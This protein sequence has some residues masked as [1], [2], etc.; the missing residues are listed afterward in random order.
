[1]GGLGNILVVDDEPD[2][3]KKLE[4][5]LFED[6]FSVQTAEGVEDALEVLQKHPTHVAVI[7]LRL[8]GANSSED[9]G[10]ALLE[11]VHRLGLSGM[12]CS[13]V[14][15]GYATLA[16][17]S[18]AFTE[19][20]VVDFFEKN[21]FDSQ[22]Q[23]FRQ[24]VKKA[25]LKA[26]YAQLSKLGFKCFKTGA[27]CSHIIVEDP[28]R[29]FVAMPYR[30]EQNNVYEY[31]LK[32]LESSLDCEIGRADEKVLSIDL[33]CKICQFIQ[34]ASICVA[35]ITTWNANVMFELGLMYGWGKP[36]ILI[37]QREE[38]NEKADLKGMEFIPYDM[39]DYPRLQES[40]T[41][42][43]QAMGIRVEETKP[44]M[45][46]GRL[47]EAEL[48]AET[49]AEIREL[50]GQ[51]QLEQVLEKLSGVKVYQREGAQLS[52]RLARVR[53]Q[54]RQGTITRDDADAERA[55]IAEAILDLFSS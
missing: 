2:W 37:K 33:M 35:D 51:D 10:F 23:K 15:T 13:I 18:H 41:A 24:A 48:D 52:R 25:V 30:P 8:R 43:L 31:G 27:R 47:A 4:A 40:L 39:D 29:I 42:V 11:E 5:I 1:M 21:K 55:R 49:I 17:A 14:L 19:Y 26:K 12:I 45:E 22:I 54:N 7:D 20:N 50:V 53:R 44:A 34:K 38:Q 46:A 6:G 32:P 28:K 16:K 3:R 9:E 36:V